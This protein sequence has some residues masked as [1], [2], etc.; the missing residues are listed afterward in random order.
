MAPSDLA[1]MAADPVFL[2]AVLDFVLLDDAHV[3][4]F[5]S[6]ADLPPDAPLRARQA[7]PGGAEVNWT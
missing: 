5:C 3:L 6:A 1:Q 2:G 4:A 7:L